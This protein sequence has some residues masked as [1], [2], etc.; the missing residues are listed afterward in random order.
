MNDLYSVFAKSAQRPTIMCDVDNTLAWSMNQSLGMLNAM[1]HTNISLQDVT[2]YHFEA[3]LPFEQSTWL[4]KQYARSTTYVNVA[5]DFH[6]IDA[7]NTLHD[8]G[9]NVVIATSRDS[10]MKSVTENWLNEWGVKHNDLFVGPTVKSEYVTANKNVVAIDDDP[11]TALELAALG[12]KVF[13]PERTYTPLW[14]KSSKMTTVQVFSVWD[15]VL[16]Q[17]T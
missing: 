11:S 2:V 4:K 14:C 10:Q 6:A 12:A 5:P 7:I 15:T 17:L 16:N 8:R 13:I 3:N 9:Y 1:F